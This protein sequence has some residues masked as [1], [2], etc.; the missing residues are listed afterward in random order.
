MPSTGQ[1][2]NF[3][4]IIW[5]KLTGKIASSDVWKVS[6]EK[7][8]IYFCL[9]GTNKKWI[10]PFR[11]HENPTQEW[12]TSGSK[13][14]YC[15][16]YVS[17]NYTQYQVLLDL[18]QHWLLYDPSTSQSLRDCQ[19]GIPWEKSSGRAAYWSRDEP[20][21]LITIQKL[22]NTYS[23]SVNT[24]PEGGNKPRWGIIAV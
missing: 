3:A 18:P 4:W 10:T 24:R 20:C 9:K 21:P 16:Q 2:I 7:E 14:L 6:Y 13:S 11:L 23:T 5:I 22:R 1:N 8:E 17:C 15:G 12:V 19:Y